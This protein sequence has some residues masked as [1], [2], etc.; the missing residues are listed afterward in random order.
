MVHA[1]VDTVCAKLGH[2][3]GKEG[4]AGGVRRFARAAKGIG[5]DGDAESGGAEERGTKG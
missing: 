1:D 4:G 5:E 2:E 3:R